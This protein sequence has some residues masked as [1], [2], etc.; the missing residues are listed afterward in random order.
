MIC[1]DCIFSVNVEFD[2]FKNLGAGEIFTNEELAG[3]VSL[4]LLDEGDLVVQS[5]NF[6]PIYTLS[7]VDGEDVLI[8]KLKDIKADN[9]IVNFHFIRA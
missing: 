9:K 6:T 4:E 7:S 3:N 1:E 5:L 8:R 2:S